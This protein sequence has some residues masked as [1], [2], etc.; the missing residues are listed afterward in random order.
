MTNAG[1]VGLIGLGEIGRVH[2]AGI[3]RSRAA[4]LAAVADTVPERLEPFAAEGVPAH[5]DAGDLIADPRI[6]TVSVRLP[7]HLHFPVA[8]AAIRAGRHVLVESRWRSG[9]SSARNSSRPPRRRA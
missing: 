6:G 7:H 9:W 3:R 8:L 2:S 1:A 5:Q 4:R